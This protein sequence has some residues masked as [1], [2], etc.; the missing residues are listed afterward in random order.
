LEFSKALLRK[1]S[2]FLQEKENLKRSNRVLQIFNG[3]QELIDA[4]VNIKAE[5]Q[6]NKLCKE[7]KSKESLEV[8][9]LESQQE[10]YESLIR[11]LENDL[12]NHMK[13][14]FFFLHH[15]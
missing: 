5:S 10:S 6:F 7:M 15:N 13:V 9:A 2:E 8:N 12:R 11:K 1:S 4:L 3:F 14:I